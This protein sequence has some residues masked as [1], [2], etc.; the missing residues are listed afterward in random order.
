ML[1]T[2]AVVTRHSAQGATDRNVTR[3]AVVDPLDAL[4]YCGCGREE[5]SGEIARERR[6]APAD[7]RP[8]R[9]SI[10]EGHS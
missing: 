3:I 2:R 7:R 4:G 6:D 10:E 5:H 9:R 1:V 8:S